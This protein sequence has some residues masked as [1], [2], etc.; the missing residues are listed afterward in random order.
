MQQQV[1]DLFENILLSQADDEKVMIV[2]MHYLGLITV[3]SIES[4]S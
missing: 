2:S 3:K 4:F 1:K